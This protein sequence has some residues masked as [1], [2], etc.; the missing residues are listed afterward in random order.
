MSDARQVLDRCIRGMRIS[1][2]FSSCGAC[3]RG[4]TKCS[5][6]KVEPHV[7]IGPWSHARLYV[8]TV[9]IL[10]AVEKRRRWKGGTRSRAAFFVVLYPPSAPNPSST[11]CCAM[12]FFPPRFALALPFLNRGTAPSPVPPSPVGPVPPAFLAWPT[13]CRVS[14]RASRLGGSWE[15]P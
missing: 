4:R 11:C 5:S 14:F 6:L 3:S 7:T 15:A 2:T 8:D 1:A 10:N 13:T 9:C 12:P